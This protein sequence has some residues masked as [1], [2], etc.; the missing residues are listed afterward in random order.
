[1]CTHKS[2][3]LVCTDSSINYKWIVRLVRV[4][5]LTGRSL[6]ILASTVPVDSQCVFF[7][8]ILH[9]IHTFAYKNICVLHFRHFQGSV[10][11]CSKSYSKVN[12]KAVPERF[13]VI[14]FCYKN[15]N[16][17]TMTYIVWSHSGPILEWILVMSFALTDPV[18]CLHSMITSDKP[19][20]GLTSP[21]R[22][23]KPAGTGLI[24]GICWGH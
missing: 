24:S 4:W 7:S 8:H 6:Y 2:T 12:K 22:T 11:K 16:D 15:V 13:L 9:L 1:M 10:A 18:F 3:R 5:T 14:Q 17:E 19:S 20:S 23:I 21:F